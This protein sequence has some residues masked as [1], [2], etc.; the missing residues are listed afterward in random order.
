MKSTINTNL[1][2]KRICLISTD[3]WLKR[4]LLIYD[5]TEEELKLIRKHVLI[6]RRRE[7]IEAHKARFDLISKLL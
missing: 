4:L 7:R 2:I 3:S 1:I 6:K 5:Y